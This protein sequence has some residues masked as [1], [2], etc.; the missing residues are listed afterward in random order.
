MKMNKRALLGTIFLAVIVVL[1]LGGGIFYY[2]LRT[3]GVKITSGNVVVDIKYNDT[4]ENSEEQEDI[5]I[6]ES[7]KILNETNI[8]ETDLMQNDSLEYQ[9]LS[10]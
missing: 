9:N 4:S 8:S 2:K 10:E 1:L 3:D 6:I 7:P 5:G